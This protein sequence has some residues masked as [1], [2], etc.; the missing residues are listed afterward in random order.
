MS[1]SYKFYNSTVLAWAGMRQ[2][3]LEAKSSIYWEIFM[4]VDDDAGK[5]FIDLL[6]A[7]AQAGLDVKIIVDGFGSYDLSKEA[8]VQMRNAGIKFLIFNHLRPGFSIYGWWRRVWHRTHRKVLIIDKDI[9][10]IGGVNVAQDSA[11]WHDLHLRLTGKTVVPILFAFGRAYVR[12]GGDKRD[13][14]DLLRPKLVAKISS[15]KEK[16]KLIL[17]SPLGSTRKSPFKKF[18]K[19]ALSTAKESFNLLTP[20]YV[21]DKIFLDLIAKA[22]ARGVKINIITPWRTDERL[23]R[24]MA[25]M[26]FSISAKAGAVFYFLR[27]MNHGKAV[28]VDGKL[29]MVGSANLTPRSFYINHEA[30]VVFSDKKMVEDLNKIFDELKKEAVPLSE[31]GL[32]NKIGWHRRLKDWLV[33]KIRDYV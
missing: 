24:Y 23:M 8:I 2:A 17:H 33:N 14:Q 12:A 18:Y 7:K 9:L 1:F 6:C 4:F 26:F 13:V 15:F 32:N 11:S 28:T 19:D 29:G 30:G 21:P 22:H 20:Y 3:I 31:L 16:I 27:K 10:F 5:P 25:S